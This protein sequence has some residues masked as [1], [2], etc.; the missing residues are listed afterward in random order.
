MAASKKADATTTAA[1]TTT[2]ASTTADESKTEATKTNVDTSNAGSTSKPMDFQSKTVPFSLE[3]GKND[4]AA[5]YLFNTC[6]LDSDVAL[7]IE[8]N[9]QAIEQV[10][11]LLRDIRPDQITNDIKDDLIKIHCIARGIRIPFL[12]QTIGYLL[13][14][15]TTVVF[16]PI[17]YHHSR[18]SLDDIEKS[19]NDNQI[20]NQKSK[21][22]ILKCCIRVNF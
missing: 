5:K 12:H 2:T 14:M 17:Y 13:I 22:M 18:I 10:V 4:D 1:T 16:Q 20:I 15:V 9:R 6:K 8:K 7:K 11:N 21:Q 3:M 19:F